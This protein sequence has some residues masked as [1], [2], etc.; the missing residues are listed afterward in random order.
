MAIINLMQKIR[1]LHNQFSAMNIF[2]DNLKKNFNLL[3]N[4]FV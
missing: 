4:T 3:R 1:Q 2:L